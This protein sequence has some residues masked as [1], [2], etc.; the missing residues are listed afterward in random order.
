M[1]KPRSVQQGAIRPLLI[2]AAVVA[3]LLLLGTRTVS[4]RA[5]D[6]TADQIA[7]AET[8]RAEFGF[9][10]DPDYVQTTFDNPNYTTDDWSVPLSKT[11]VAD[12]ASRTQVREAI[13]P[14]LSKADTEPGFAGAYIDQQRSGLPVFLSTDAQ[15]LTKAISPLVPDGISVEVRQVERSW[16]DLQAI[17]GKLA[18]DDK[19]LASEGVAVISAG[20]D[21]SS[22]MVHVAI[23]DVTP[24]PSR[25]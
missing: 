8:F 9:R 16:D 10:A 5:T 12:L 25:R 20:I 6:L 3:A 1:A 19:E 18:A 4:T 15:S 24:S 2:V 11:E 17:K 22:N 23:S 14:A 7:F 21:T 13:Q